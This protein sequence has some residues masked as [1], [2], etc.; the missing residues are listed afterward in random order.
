[1]PR[2]FDI[3]KWIQIAKFTTTVGE[4]APFPYIKGAAGCVAT[5]LEAIEKAGKNNKDL[6]TLADNIGMTMDI[7]KETI[8]AHGISS[9]TH[10]Q[11]VCADFQTYL[12]NLLSDM[13]KTQR[14]LEG[15]QFKRFL[16]ALKARKVAD[17]INDYKQRMNN[18]KSDYST[19][20]SRC[21]RCEIH[22][23]QE[24]QREVREHTT[25]IWA[26]L[27]DKKG[28][29]KGMVQDLAFSDIELIERIPQACSACHYES[30]H[31]A[32]S[33]WSHTCPA[34]CGYQDGYCAVEQSNKIKIIRMYQPSIN[35]GRDAMK[36]LDNNINILTKSKHENI[37]QVYGS[38]SFL[39]LICSS[40]LI[41]VGTKQIPVEEY[42]N[43][44]PKKE[45]VQFYIQ[46]IH[47]RESVSNHLRTSYS[48]D[49]VT[50]DNYAGPNDTY[51]NE[52]NRLVIASICHNYNLGINLH[53]EEYLGIMKN[54]RYGIPYIGSGYANGFGGAFMS[55]L[56]KAHII[57][58]YTIILFHYQIKLDEVSHQTLIGRVW[59]MSGIWL[60]SWDHEL[61]DWTTR[62]PTITLGSH[63]TEGGTVPL[64]H[65]GV[66]CY[67]FQIFLA[68]GPGYTWIAQASQLYSYLNSGG[69][70]NDYD[71]YMTDG[72]WSID[73]KPKD[74]QDSFRLCDT[75]MVE[76]PHMLSLFIHPPIVDH[77]TN[78]MSP[79]VLSW[80]Y[81]ADSEMSLEEAEEV[82][83]FKFMI[84]WESRSSP[85]GADVCEHYGLPILEIFNAPEFM[86]ESMMIC[87][88]NE[89]SD[90]MSIISDGAHQTLHDEGG[91]PQEN[92][93][94]LMEDAIE[95]VEEGCTNEVPTKAKITTVL[96]HN[97]PSRYQELCIMVI[98]FIST[99]L[100]SLVVQACLQ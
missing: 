51:I 42:L 55:G 21:P 20:D 71:L 97:I 5:I 96:Q 24:V 52:H 1:M 67:D 48:P 91:S 98:T 39:P 33:T 26:K 3:D 50:W 44:I 93:M 94:G 38:L 25:Q 37:A 31:G 65:A 77:Q 18:I 61:H 100:L 19:H 74:R 10:F 82:F 75:F 14:N 69:Q 12:E 7:V 99:L 88:A 79:P 9:V 15:K 53:P 2:N 41:W 29:Y 80:L 72:Y 90:P 22:S 40:L 92:I 11:A 64:L 56:K 95:G 46:F 6:R 58:V 86:E 27:Q 8:E 28:Y 76:D 62:K 30:I 43:S 36:Q 4:M 17:S 87:A 70:V 16:K 54:D 35:N 23:L 49:T 63:S 89:A 45:F 32:L 57:S 60:A 47:D 78:K 66:A 83:N 85:K 59:N 34:F 73:V 81:G 84:S 13:S 68:H